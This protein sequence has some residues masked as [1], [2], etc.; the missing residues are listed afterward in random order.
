MGTQVRDLEQMMRTLAEASNDPNSVT[1]GDFANAVECLQAELKMLESEVD[2]LGGTVIKAFAPDANDDF[3]G[4]TK[5][6]ST[7][8]TGPV[9]VNARSKRVSY[10]WTDDQGRN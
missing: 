3:T 1:V 5:F 10:H 4:A 7:S 8:D 2:K 9:L 6:E